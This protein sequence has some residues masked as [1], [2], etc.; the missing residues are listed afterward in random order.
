ME[1]RSSWLSTRGKVP[2][3]D[4]GFWV[5]I[6]MCGCGRGHDSPSTLTWRSSIVSRSADCVRGGVR[7]SSSTRTTLAKTGPGRKS[8]LPVS[9]PKTETPVIV[10]GEEVGVALD[11]GQLRPEGGGEGAGQHGLADAR[12]RPR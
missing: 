8:Q 4:C 11:P 3:C 6:T 1:K 10:G 9:G 5:A 7:L 12:A 2:R